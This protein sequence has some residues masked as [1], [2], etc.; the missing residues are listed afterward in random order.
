MLASDTFNICVLKNKN[1]LEKV[2]DFQ[3]ITEYFNKKSFPAAVW[4]WNDNCASKE[5]MEES[6]FGLS[7]IEK[8]MYIDTCKIKEKDLKYEGFTIKKV[9]SDKQ[10]EDFSKV[11]ASIF[12]ET[13]EAHYVKRQYDILGQKKIYTDIEMTF[14]VGYFDGTPVS[15]GTV[16]VTEESTGIYDVAVKEDCRKKG[17][18]SA[19]FAYLMGEAKKNN[20]EYCILQA[21]SDGAGIYR[22]MGFTDVCDIDVYENRDFL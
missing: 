19:M 7:E 14:F 6:G 12:G 4:L 8:G 21:S 3:E 22:K 15:C 1:S 5:R 13:E 17:F 18:G 10:M 11:I 9:S 2:E 16:Y 20:T